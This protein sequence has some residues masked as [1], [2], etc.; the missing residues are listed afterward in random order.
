MALRHED[1][2]RKEFDYLGKPGRER[3]INFLVFDCTGGCGKEVR[4]YDAPYVLKRANGRCIECHLKYI[5]GLGTAH[6]KKRPFERLYNNFVGAAKNKTDRR[7]HIRSIGMHL[8]YE[9]FLEFTRTPKCHYCEILINW[10]PFGSK[11]TSRY[12][13]DRKDNR[14]GYSK[15]NCVVCCWPCN[16]LKGD[17]LTYA[18]MLLLRDGLKKIRL[19]SGLHT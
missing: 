13:L 16:E 7:R 10:V 1:A 18:E 2:I 8:T 6:S 14:Q 5:S 19:A 3:K 15:E 17:R 9:E 12:N 4:M 11:R